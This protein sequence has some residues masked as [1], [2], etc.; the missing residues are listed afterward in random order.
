MT[1]TTTRPYPIVEMREL[2]RPSRTGLWGIGPRT[3]HDV[4]R[5]REGH[6]VLVYKVGNRYVVDNMNLGP[7]DDKVI[8]A[9][10]VTV[11]D[12]GR[13]TPVEVE[14]T[15]PSRD[16]SFFTVVVTFACSV[17]EPVEVVQGGIT[18]PG[19]ILLTY[20][21][22][23][24]GYSQ[25]GIGFPIADVNEARRYINAQLSA[26]A[27]VCEPEIAGMSVTMA[28]VEVRTPAEEKAKADARRQMRDW[29]DLENERVD[30]DGELRG[31]KQHTE[32]GISRTKQ[33]NEHELRRSAQANDQDYDD[34]DR[35]YR[36]LREDEEQVHSIR[37][38][39]I[40][41]AAR[42]EERR[43]AI[44]ARR[45]E[46]EAE[47]ARMGMTE[48]Y[49]LTALRANA[50]LLD[51]PVRALQL[52]YLSG[53]MTAAELARG[54]QEMTDH[55][56][57]LDRDRADH[58]HEIERD[59]QRNEAGERRDQL[60]FD[61]EVK[62][63][64]LAARQAEANRQAEE[65]RLE[66][67]NTRERES[68]AMMWDRHDKL[69]AKREEEERRQREHADEIAARRANENL[70][71]QVYQA[72]IDLGKSAVDRGLLDTSSMD[73]AEILRLDNNGMPVLAGNE[74]GQL[75]DQPA[76]AAGGES[77]AAPG[78]QPERD[79]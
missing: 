26:Y 65:A 13:Q 12:L 27:T 9:S 50:E 73:I 62:R 35:R 30:L 66:R 61:R 58:Q 23:H 42:D 55:Q 36:H 14:L 47:L 19:T 41:R 38:A 45:L 46:L 77:G 21:K 68:L 76:P 2:H 3:R 31:H 15:I 70:Q 1:P 59:R 34:A 40:S 57:K 48:E 5:P 7:R 8:N 22:N 6:F 54:I 37:A 11:V 18:D 25:M 64:E 10:Q 60:E 43:D 74:P 39:R 49:R 20:L 79:S 75:P 4:P 33:E 51:D 72:R 16:H 53:N 29:H 32:H 63:A 44:A 52:S 17:D 69:I 28:S 56:A 24:H 78:D 67:E 71:R